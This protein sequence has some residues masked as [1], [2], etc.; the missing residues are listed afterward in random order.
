MDIKIGITDIAREL[1]I[2]T[3]VS[4]DEV[5]R[6]LREALADDGVLMLSDDKGR[7]VLIPAGKIGYLDL[8]QEHSRPVGFGAVTS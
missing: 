4:S 6:A 7:K 8:G 2:E 3:T 5:E 1:N